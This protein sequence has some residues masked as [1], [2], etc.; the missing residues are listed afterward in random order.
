MRRR[1]TLPFVLVV[2][3]LGPQA[4]AGWQSLGRLP[5]PRVTPRGLEYRDG[6]VALDVQAVA[7][8]VV[9]VRFVPRPAF[10]P[11]FSWSLAEPRPEPPP[12][13][14]SRRDT[15]DVLEAGGLRVLVRR[16]T[17][18]L[19]VQSADGAA[20]EADDPER[21]LAWAGEAIL[22]SKRLRDDEHVYGLGEKAG[23]LDKRGWQLGGTSV[24]M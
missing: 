4:L 16:D 12:A 9:R 22:L 8:G 1:P 10:G 23:P 18:R 20:L 7:E 5:A 11:D 13:R 3:A 15:S 24:A 17:G 2:L 19:E 6:R 14:V 21:G